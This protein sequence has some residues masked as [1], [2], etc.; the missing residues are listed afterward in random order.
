MKVWLFLVVV[1]A[2][3]FASCESKNPVKEY[4]DTVVKGYKG[5][6][7]AG[8]RASVKNLQD[9]ISGFQAANGRYPKDL[10]ELEAF[11]GETLDS[12]KYEYDPSTGIITSKE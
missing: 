4:G 1:V 10:K 12:A 2:F 8:S 3:A 7:K 11:T 5:A 9:S 6:Q